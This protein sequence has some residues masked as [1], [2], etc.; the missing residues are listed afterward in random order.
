M[1]M[2]LSDLKVKQKAMIKGFQGESSIQERLM[3]LGMVPG[4]RILL[5]RLA[6]LGDP[7]EIIVRGYSLSIRKEDAQQILITPLLS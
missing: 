5:K 1:T 2:L 7:M 6:P 3:E 4:T